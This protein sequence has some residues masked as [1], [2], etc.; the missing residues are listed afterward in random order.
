MRSSPTITRCCRWLRPSSTP[1]TV[2]RRNWARAC[3]RPR[4]RFRRAGASTSPIRRGPGRESGWARR[5]LG[6]RHLPGAPQ[7]REPRDHRDREH[8]RAPARRC[9][10]LLLARE[11]GARA[12]LPA[13]HRA[14]QA[15]DARAAQDRA[16]ESLRRLPRRHEGRFGVHFDQNCARY[17]NGVA[18]ARGLAA[19]QAQ[20]FGASTSPAATS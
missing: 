17:E 12:G 5:G 6:Q 1:T 4:R 14:G 13:S 19:F 15:H 2:R 20:N 9:Q 18:T 7:G 8:D 10:R 11:H 16:T 3:G